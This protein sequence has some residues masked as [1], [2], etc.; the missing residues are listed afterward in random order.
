MHKIRLHLENRY[1]F[2]DPR[3]ITTWSVPEVRFHGVGSTLISGQHNRDCS[4][5]GPAW[6]PAVAQFQTHPWGIS[7][8]SN[9]SLA[10][11]SYSGA[12]ESPQD[13]GGHQQDTLRGRWF[14][15]ILCAKTRKE[16]SVRDAANIYQ[17]LPTCQVPS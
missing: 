8:S 10:F 4:C 11:S 5:S 13:R 14:Y 6:K 12:H 9:P 3:L 17:M 7:T 2:A 15:V 16:C 1:R